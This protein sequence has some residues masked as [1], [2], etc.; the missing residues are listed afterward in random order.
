M[1]IFLP[2]CEQL[3][4]SMGML[5]MV[6]RPKAPAAAAESAVSVVFI[7]M[8]EVMTFSLYSV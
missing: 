3:L 2:Y 8:M 1:I 4:W 6:L 5:N 7:T